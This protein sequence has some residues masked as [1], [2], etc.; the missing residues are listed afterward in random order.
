MTQDDEFTLQT[1][2]VWYGGREVDYGQ[3]KQYA[4]AAQHPAHVLAMQECW[5]TAAENLAARLGAFHAQHGW[6]TAVVS[7]APLTPVRTTTLPYAQAALVEPVPGQGEVLVWSVHLAPYP[8]APYRALAGEGQ[9][10]ADYEE[11]PRVEQ[12]RAV[13]RETERILAQQPR[14]ALPVVVCGDFNAP[15]TGD[16]R[17]REDRPDIRWASTDALLEAG[18]VDSFRQV[19]PD[20]LLSPADTWSPIEPLTHAGHAQK[21]EDGR[22]DGAEPR[23]RIDFIFSRGLTVKDSVMRGCTAEGLVEPGFEDVGGACDLIPDHRGNRFPSD[24]QVVE[25]RFAFPAAE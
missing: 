2:N 22:T 6:D 3:E 9:A 14:G 5:G 25:T 7:S 21:P 12:I 16:W 15:A 24:H 23:D 20:A 10:T 4:I 19:H 1:W 8:Y 18:F 11:E 13:L 17:D